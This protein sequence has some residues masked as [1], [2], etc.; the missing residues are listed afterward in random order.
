MKPYGAVLAAVLG[1]VFS[2]T[3]S[4][5]AQSDPAGCAVCLGSSGESKKAGWLG[6]SIS[7]LTGENAKRIKPGTSSG[8]LVRDVVEDSPAEAAGIEEDDVIVE[9]NGKAIADADDLTSTVRK[10]KPGETVSVVVYRGDQ[11]K[12]LRVTVGKYRSDL[13]HLGIAVPDVPPVHVRVFG[14]SE[15]DGLKVLTLNS[16]LGEYFGAPRGKGVLVERVKGKSAAAKA[17]FKAG[18]VI[19]KLGD[20]EIEESDDLWS[21]MEEYE[22][23]DTATFS[24]LRKGASL[25]LAMMV[26]DTREHSLKLFRHEFHKP[27]KMES[28]SYWFDGDDLREKMKRLQEDLKSVGEQVRVKMLDIRKKL[29]RE[30][31]M[32]GT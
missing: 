18:D 27:L 3:P 30:L 17:G 6:V 9:F 8:A 22:E 14:G 16:Q 11:K 26:T 21:A 12:S 23:G 20:E 24:I 10:T 29:E 1:V 2:G 4:A 7:D 15:I 32:V 25:T 13:A 19:L 28:R 5:Q 31:R